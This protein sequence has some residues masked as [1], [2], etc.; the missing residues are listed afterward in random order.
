MQKLWTVL[1]LYKAENLKQYIFLRN[2]FRICGFIVGNGK[3]HEDNK[4]NI[5]EKK[6]E[7]LFTVSLSQDI[8]LNGESNTFFKLD[9]CKDSK[10]LIIS[11][12][13]KMSD[14]RLIQSNEYDILQQITRLYINNYI[15][16]HEYNCKHFHYDEEQMN[17]AYSAYCKME[18]ELFELL[19]ERY[20]K[21]G[22]SP[23]I[24]HARYYSIWRVTQIEELFEKQNRYNIE[25]VLLALDDDA[26]EST[27]I[28][29]FYYLRGRICEAKKQW[30]NAEKGYYMFL[31]R[32]QGMRFSSFIWYR[33]GKVEEEKL[34][35]EESI[36][37][38]QKAFDL[39]KD[40][41]KAKYKL[42]VY[43][44]FSKT[45]YNYEKAEQLYQELLE[46]VYKMLSEGTI[47]PREL[48]YLFKLYFRCGRLYLKRLHNMSKAAEYFQKAENMESISIKQM[49]F[50][51]EFYG[52]EA[53]KFLKIVL[54]RFPMRQVRI[55]RQEAEL[56]QKI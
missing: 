3:I 24:Q 55:N 27:K 43:Y 1:I 54:N 25:K 20:N 2:F 4:E 22:V 21:E 12:L 16:I 53:E 34:G 5:E 14:Y 56:N 17:A 8:S 40:S 37:Y 32:T 42:A 39:N 50:L 6:K 49:S 30:K 26:D 38:Y 9:D 10:Q 47:E 44:E 23:I 28:V 52:E 11:V 15:G 19:K 46:Q 35:L 33:L 36:Q 29:S 18:M 7:F 51:R 13:S 31:E 45:N 41:Y 48:E